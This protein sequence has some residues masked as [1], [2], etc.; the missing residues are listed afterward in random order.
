MKF[1]NGENGKTKRKIQKAREKVKSIDSEI[2]GALIKRCILVICNNAS[3][4]KF[5]CC[6]QGKA[7][8][9]M[10]RKLKKFIFPTIEA[11]WL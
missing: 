7:S 1:N 4:S 6:C 5:N 10:A 3:V 2:V 9:N 8:Y 11:F